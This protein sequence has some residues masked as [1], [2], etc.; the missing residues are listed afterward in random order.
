VTKAD[1]LVL[2]GYL[3]LI[4]GACIIYRPLGFI[5]AGAICLLLGWT[6]AKSQRPRA[7]RY[8]WQES[9]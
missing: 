9:E 5:V 3:L 7:K 6:N 1:W 2:A 8:P 4:A